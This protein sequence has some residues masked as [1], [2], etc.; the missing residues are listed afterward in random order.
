MPGRDRRHGE[1][2]DRSVTLLHDYLFLSSD[3]AQSLSETRGFRVWGI[4]QTPAQ[5]L[6]K[7][8]NWRES[9]WTS[10]TNN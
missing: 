7:R 4:L 2:F 10:L 1:P 6:R 5:P 8:D 9:S 3:L